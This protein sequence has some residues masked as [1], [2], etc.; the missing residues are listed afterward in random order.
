MSVYESLRLGSG[1]SLLE[2]LQSQLKQREGEIIQLQ[3]T[4]F[5]IYLF[6][7]FLNLNKMVQIDI[8]IKLL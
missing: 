5:K 1:S 7:L 3:V 8:L 2:N 4:F 6:N